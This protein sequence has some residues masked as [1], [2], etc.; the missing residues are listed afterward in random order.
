MSDQ[1]FLD[2]LKEL[3]PLVFK[4]L[5]DISTPVG[6]NDI[7]E[8]ASAVIEYEI[9]DFPEELKELIY[10]VQLKSKF[11]ILRYYLNHT[12]PYIDG[13]IAMAEKLSYLTCEDC[14]QKGSSRVIG[15]WS[16]TLCEKDYQ[17]ALANKSPGR[18]FKNS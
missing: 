1:N 15:T 4:N 11:G 8:S 6:W 14:G 12:T 2:R 5:D 7:I 10:A 3:Y 13:V 9:Q 17:K 18:N 16:C